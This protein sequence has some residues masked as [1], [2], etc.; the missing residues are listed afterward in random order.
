M[1]DPPPI[2][3]GTPAPVQV[4]TP[5]TQR[6]VPTQPTGPVGITPEI[7]EWYNQNFPI[8]IPSMS[9]TVYPPHYNWSH[10]QIL[11]MYFCRV[12]VAHRNHLFWKS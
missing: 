2:T 10:A 6:T 1:A 7:S 4:P 8:S 12:R 5:P 3:I 9:P 11:L